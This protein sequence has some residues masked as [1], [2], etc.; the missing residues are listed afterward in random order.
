MSSKDLVVPESREYVVA[1]KPLHRDWQSISRRMLTRFPQHSDPEPRQHT[2]ANGGGEPPPNFNSR[3][4]FMLS[5][6]LEEHNKT[7]LTITESLFAKARLVP[8]ST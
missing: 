1:Q 8:S 6:W 5:M 7:K 3:P 4:S 2:A